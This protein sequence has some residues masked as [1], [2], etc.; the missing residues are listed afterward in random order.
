LQLILPLEN[1]GIFLVG[2]ATGGSHWGR[3]VELV[4]PLTDSG[5]ITDCSTGERRPAP[6]LDRTLELALVEGVQAS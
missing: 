1:V 6:P 2:A 5:P 3:Y 4:L